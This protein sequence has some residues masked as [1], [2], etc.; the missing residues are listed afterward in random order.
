MP[1]ESV[2]MERPKWFK[3]SNNFQT[4]LITALVLAPVILAIVAVGSWIYDAMILIVTI[5]IAMEWEWIVTSK[6]S[7]KLDSKT[8]RKWR[9][10]G[11]LYAAVFGVSVIYLRNMEGGLGLVMYLLVIVWSMD[12]GAYLVGRF[13]GGPKI[14]TAISP[15]KTWSGLFGGLTASAIA[16]AIISFFMV[17]VTVLGVVFISILLGFVSQVGDFIESW[18]KRQFNVKDSG[19]IIPGHG[20]VMDRVDSLV[21]GAPFLVFV[22][23][24][25]SGVFF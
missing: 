4:R 9:I 24:L 7:P 18:V 13:A 3:L 11:V 12:T 16:G 19:A 10:F 25:Y 6:H 2:A 20:G 17:E 14:W 15:K 8:L 5:M 22:T 1:G 21:L 23:W